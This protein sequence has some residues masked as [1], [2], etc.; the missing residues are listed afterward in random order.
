MP[1]ILYTFDFNENGYTRRENREGL[2]ANGKETIYN[3]A[4]GRPG[5]ISKENQK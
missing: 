3:N 1:C 5:R 2:R 4:V